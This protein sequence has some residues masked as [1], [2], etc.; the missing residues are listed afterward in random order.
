MLGLKKSNKLKIVC[1]SLLVI[2]IIG[3]IIL[4]SFKISN[5]IPKIEVS[6]VTF[7]VLSIITVRFYFNE[8]LLFL[9]SNKKWL[10]LFALFVL[11]SI[12]SIIYNGRYLEIRD[13]FEPLKY[14]KLFSFIVFFYLFSDIRKWR[15]VIEVVFLCLVIFNILHYF[16]IANFNSVIEP[17]Y[18]A[19]HHL[20]SFG[21]N[22]IGEKATKR[23]IGTMGNPN[24]NALLF[25][26]FT[27]LFLPRKKKNMMFHIFFSCLAMV[28]VF[29]CQSRT[30]F[31]CLI[32]L[33]ISYFIFIFPGWKTFFVFVFTCSFGFVV[34][35]STGNSY[36]SSISSSSQVLKAT[37]GR[38]QQ[39]ESIIKYTKGKELL[40]NGVNKQLMRDK[41]IYAE[42]EYFLIYF[43]YG[44]IGLITFLAVYFALFFKCVKNYKTRGASMILG[45]IIIF[46]I[47]GITNSPLHSSKL[48]FI[49]AM[50]VG[51]AF[52]FSNR[53]KV[54]NA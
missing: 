32:V 36:I 8:L 34:F 2:S 11:I 39:W 25:V 48:S 12:I 49:F 37:S 30:G 28:G 5:S 40:G 19:D 14:F 41:E 26:I 21:L 33:M 22:S 9:K 24:N 4:P 52:L 31:V 46:G 1:F 13:L 50:M 45:L 54:I 23:M 6:D 42:S 7:V 27:M 38:T 43:R 18:A 35:K 44:I 17:F 10:L 29:A 51:V 47:A 53:L 20:N 3:A 15:V 16:N